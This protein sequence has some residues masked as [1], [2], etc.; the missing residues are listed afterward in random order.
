[1]TLLYNSEL[2]PDSW[3]EPTNPEEFVKQYLNNIWPGK[4]CM[5]CKHWRCVHRTIGVCR[6]DHGY[7]ADS[8]DTC[9]NWEFI[10]E[11]N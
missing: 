8:E 6:A 4:V 11:G 10:Y 1:M 5:N 3:Q 7:P 9:D 2:E